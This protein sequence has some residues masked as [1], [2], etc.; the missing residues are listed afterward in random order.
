M[1]RPSQSDANIAHA[2]GH[3]EKL[4]VLQTIT[5]GNVATSSSHQVK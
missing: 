4:S 3:V 5:Q 1:M 2:E